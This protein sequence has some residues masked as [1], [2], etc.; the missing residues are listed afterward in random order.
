[1]LKMVIELEGKS[2]R[3]LMAALRFAHQYCT[4]G[5]YRFDELP[6][7]GVGEFPGNSILEGS[8]NWRYKFEIEGEAEPDED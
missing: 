4:R 6:R 7:D 1:M 8:D 5:E 3:D 2:K